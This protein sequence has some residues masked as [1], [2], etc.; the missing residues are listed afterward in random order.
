[1]RVAGPLR[2][3]SILVHEAAIGTDLGGK[4]VLTVGAENVVDRRYVQLGPVQDDGKVV[5]E[6]GLEG[7]E[8]YI[9][10]GL[11]RARPGFPVNPTE[12]EGS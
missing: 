10:G 6:E 12:A 7:D 2:E 5:V 11:L 1:M 4:Y 9:L 3:D 8:R